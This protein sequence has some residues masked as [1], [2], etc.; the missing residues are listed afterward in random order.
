MKEIYLFP[1]LNEENAT[2]YGLKIGDFKLEHN[3]QELT[4]NEK[5]V[6]IKE[7]DTTWSA[8]NKG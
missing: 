3:G 1:V 4:F 5:D 7:G 6:L 2:E 8:Q